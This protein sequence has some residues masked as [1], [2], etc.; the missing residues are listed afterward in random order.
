MEQ[1]YS[2]LDQ[3]LIKIGFTGTLESSSLVI[4]ISPELIESVPDETI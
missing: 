3:K 2:P 4:T 1:P